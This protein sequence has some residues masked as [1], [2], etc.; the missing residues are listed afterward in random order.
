MPTTS[1][2]KHEQHSKAKAWHGTRPGAVCLLSFLIF[3]FLL[4]GVGF[5]QVKENGNI[6]ADCHEGASGVPG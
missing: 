4:P 5:W 3:L 1:Q 2:K 6:H